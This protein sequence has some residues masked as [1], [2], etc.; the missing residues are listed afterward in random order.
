MSLR[1]RRKRIHNRRPSRI[2]SFEDESSI[3]DGA[4]HE[5]PLR[6]I[7]FVRVHV[8]ELSGSQQ[9]CSEQDGELSFLGHC[10]DSCVLWNEIQVREA[11]TAVYLF[12]SHQS[13]KSFTVPCATFRGLSG[14]NQVDYF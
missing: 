7:R 10:G 8:D 4:V 9:R 11:G 12:L 2:N 6:H 1:F 3:L 14:V 13:M 5:K